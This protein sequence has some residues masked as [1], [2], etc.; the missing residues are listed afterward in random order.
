MDKNQVISFI[1]SQ[2]TAGKI[3]KDDLL[4]IAGSGSA[5]ASAS[6]MVSSMP[7][8]VIVG[9]APISNN[10]TSK[11]LI[12]VLYS[13]GAIIAVIGVCVLIVQHWQEIGFFGR[14]L[15]TIGISLATYIAALLFRDPENRTLSQVLFTISAGL[16]PAGAYILLDQASIKF[17]WSAQIGTALSLFVIYG[18]ALFVN[19]LSILFLIAVAYATWAYYAVV[20]KLFSGNILY[21]IDYVQWS[22]IFL[23]VSY[24]F[25]AYG[26]QT[27]WQSRDKKDANEKEAVKNVLYGVGTLAILGSAITMGGIFDLVIIALIFA[28]FYGSVYLKNHAMLLFGALFLMGHIVKLTSK[29]FV[30]S[31]GLPVVLIIV[32]FLIIGVGYATFYINKRFISLK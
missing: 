19:R 31:I 15:V 18:V 13:I 30:D 2:I 12:H 27:L 28:A 24:I 4:S 14:M 5:S 26:Y 7:N 22:S 32:G 3:S 8:P 25:I 6:S 1:E 21:L 17:D 11:G 16:A 20:M 9:V 10:D 23:G 29:Y